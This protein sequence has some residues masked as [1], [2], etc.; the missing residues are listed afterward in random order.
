[1]RSIY[2]TRVPPCVGRINLDSTTDTT[3]DLTSE[4]TQ[5]YEPYRILYGSYQT[6]LETDPEIRN[7]A[8]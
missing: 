3:A 2:T 6:N 1:M 4:V 8:N 5:A 7:K